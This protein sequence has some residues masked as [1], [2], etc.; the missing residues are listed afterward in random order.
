MDIMS[1]KI[2]FFS[3]IIYEKTDEESKKFH[4]MFK[5][6]R[7]R[8]IF[9]LKRDLEERRKRELS[10]VSKEA[11]FKASELKARERTESKH[12]IMLLRES[13]IEKTIERLKQKFVSFAGSPD[14]GDFLMALA[15]GTTRPLEAGDYI[16][17]MTE[18]D[19][20]RYGGAVSS[21]ASAR[22]DCSFELRA[23]SNQ[24]IGGL[25]LEDRDRKFSIDNSFLSLIEDSRSDIGLRVTE[26]L[27]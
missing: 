5:A 4:D 9:E 23:G 2:T 8:Q 1:D 6:D 13:F 26:I 24:I 18:S 10:E 17:Y 27:G 15:A 20:G 19:L 12:Q 3:K 25:V 21:A 14:Y 22:Q 16:I 7:E 11:E